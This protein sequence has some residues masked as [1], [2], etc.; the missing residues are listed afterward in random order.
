MQREPINVRDINPQWI[1]RLNSNLPDEMEYADDCD[2]VRE[3][4]TAKEKINDNAKKVL[5]ENNLLVSE[6][7]TEN[8]TIKRRD[9]G[10]RSR[11]EK[12]YQTRIKAW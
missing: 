10:R 9:K 7:K 3:N 12:G 5:T 2:F 4:G 11:M 8:I 6:E 1:E